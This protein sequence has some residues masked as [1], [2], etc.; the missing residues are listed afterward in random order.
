MIRMRELEDTSVLEDLE[1][2]EEEYDEPEE[3]SLW[4]RGFIWFCQPQLVVG[5]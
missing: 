3:V 2:A 5:V 1:A 4:Q